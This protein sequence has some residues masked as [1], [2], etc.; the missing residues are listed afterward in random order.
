MVPISST[1]LA[2]WHCMRCPL[3]APCWL[4]SKHFCSESKCCFILIFQFWTFSATQHFL[5]LHHSDFPV[6]FQ[7]LKKKNPENSQKNLSFAEGKLLQALLILKSIK[8][9]QLTMWRIDTKVDRYRWDIF[10]FAS[11]SFSFIFNLFPH[12]IKICKLLVFAMQKF[13]IFCKTTIEFQH[14][15]AGKS[16]LKVRKITLEQCPEMLL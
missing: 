5:T 14:N 3:V 10:C 11:D 4:F 12:L 7:T 13:C 15:P 6:L 9:K 1:V 8:P 2:D 16:P